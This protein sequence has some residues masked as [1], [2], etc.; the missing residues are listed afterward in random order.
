MGKCVIGQ[1]MPSG[2]ASRMLHAPLGEKDTDV[3]V[4]PDSSNIFP[5]SQRGSFLPGSP[6]ETNLR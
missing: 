6:P 1:L 4:H 5:E 2:E 3:P